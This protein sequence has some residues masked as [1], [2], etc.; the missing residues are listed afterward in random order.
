MHIFIYNVHKSTDSPYV[1]KYLHT[2]MKI[3]GL[4]TVELPREGERKN[5]LQIYW[6]PGLHRPTNFKIFKISDY[7]LTWS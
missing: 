6:Q 5:A 7:S 3:Y 2:Y 4:Q 1:H